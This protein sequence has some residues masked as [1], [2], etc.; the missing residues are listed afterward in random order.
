M[1]EEE[2]AEGTAVAD[3][4]ATNEH[5]FAYVGVYPEPN[6][7]VPPINTPAEVEAMVANGTLPAPES[8][9]DAADEDT[10]PEQ[11]SA[12]E[13]TPAGGSSPVDEQTPAEGGDGS[14]AMPGLL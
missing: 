2:V 10:E 6:W 7:V 1:A 12:V 13:E 11:E 4:E 3:V 14:A 8:E 5:T 9:E